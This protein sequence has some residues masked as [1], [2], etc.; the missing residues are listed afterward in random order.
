MKQNYTEILFILDAS[1][2]M[3]GERTEAIQGLNSFIAAQK[4]LPGECKMTLVQFSSKVGLP[5]RDYVVESTPWYKV[6]RNAV[7]IKEINPITEEDYTPYGGTALLDAIG[8]GI[9]SLGARLAA[10]PESERPDKVLVAV[11]TDGGENSSQ[12][13]SS[14]K[15]KEMIKHQTDVYSWTFTFL[16]SDIK[17]VKYAHTLGYGAQNARY[18][19]SISAAMDTYS[20]AGASYRVSNVVG[21]AEAFFK[22][23]EAQP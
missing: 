13:F 11:L 4:D 22:E 10:M 1:G 7:P 6:I 17:A 20:R 15:I 2:S 8:T 21:S 23:E 5:W 16:S 3:E 19:K 14:E 18:S 12:I 9:D